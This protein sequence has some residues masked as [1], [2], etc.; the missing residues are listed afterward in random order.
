MLL[1]LPRQ[2]SLGRMQPEQNELLAVM[3]CLM[4]WCSCQAICESAS[5][6]VCAVSESVHGLNCQ[7][8]LHTT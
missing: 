2:T 5:T 6:C 1:R 4:M 7:E 3:P 8:L